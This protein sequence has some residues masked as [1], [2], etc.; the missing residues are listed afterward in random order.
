MFSTID[1]TELLKR[2][3]Q[4]SENRKILMKSTL[5]IP[6]KKQEIGII[7]TSLNTPLKTR[8]LNFLAKTICYSPS[9]TDLIKN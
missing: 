1:I 2:T 8:P 4:N 6:S 3:L 5:K 7:Q 9:F